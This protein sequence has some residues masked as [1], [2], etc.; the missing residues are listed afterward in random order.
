MPES[1]SDWDAL[2]TAVGRR[3]SSATAWSEL[4]K[5]LWPYLLDWV[6]TRYGLDTDRAGA[7]LQDAFM[8]YRSKLVAGRVDKPSLSHL[9]GF[10]KFCVL[11]AL[12]DQARLVSLDE[13]AARSA[14]GNAEQD[15]LHKLM[16]DQALDRL[17]QRCA[18]VL[19]SRYFHGR[20]S[21]EIGALLGLDAGNVDVILHRCREK[22][23]E[24]LVGITSSARQP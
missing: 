9:R 5:S 6:L 15:L 16:V 21:A 22:C 18:Y 11:K 8:Q 13:I 7:V 17:D 2:F 3:P 20:T 14:G 10:V 23:R 12:S 1:T 19:R 24:V 4:Y